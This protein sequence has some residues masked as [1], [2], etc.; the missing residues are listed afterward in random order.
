MRVY[1]MLNFWQN[2]NKCYFKCHAHSKLHVLTWLH[3]KF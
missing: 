3:Q 1:I 2:T